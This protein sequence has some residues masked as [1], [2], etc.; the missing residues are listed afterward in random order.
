[1]M[2]LGFPKRKPNPNES[3]ICRISHLRKI[4]EIWQHSGLDSNSVTSLQWS[5]VCTFTKIYL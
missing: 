2:N 3:E 5:V 1:M 4:V